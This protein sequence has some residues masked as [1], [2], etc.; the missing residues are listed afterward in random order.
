MQAK[1]I[2][3]DH[4]PNSNPTFL[5]SISLF[6]IAFL[7]HFPFLFPPPFYFPSILW[8]FFLGHLP[9]FFRR[10]FL[11][12]PVPFLIHFTYFMIVSF[13]SSLFLVMSQQQPTQVYPVSPSSIV[14]AISPL[15]FFSLR[16]FSLPPDDCHIYIHDFWRSPP[17]SLPVCSL[18][19]LDGVGG[20]G[21][22]ACEP[23]ILRHRCV[24]L[25]LCSWL[26]WMVVDFPFYLAVAHAPRR[27]CVLS[28]GGEE[29]HTPTPPMSAH[30]L[31]SNAS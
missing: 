27:R 5:V 18:L 16:I 1:F 22:C 7:F 9:P 17:P 31:D 21:K 11:G 24:L 13:F 20:D 23:V 6:N 2:F 19:L 3:Y 28:T 10:D 30:P 4:A 8:I 29:Y 26:D 12:V 25:R 15:P 14:V